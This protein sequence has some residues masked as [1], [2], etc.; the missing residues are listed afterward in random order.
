MTQYVIGAVML[1]TGV[2]ATAQAPVNVALAKRL[3]SLQA[4]VVS[5]AVG[6][7][8]LLFV[9]LATGRLAPGELRGVSWWQ[10]TGGLLGAVVVFSATVFVPRLGVLAATGAVI[11]GQFIGGA[12]IDRFGLIGMPTLQ[13]TWSRIVGLGLLS[14]GAFFVLRR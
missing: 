3:G 2:L 8:A 1:V 10:L 14:L 9:A 11:A 6:T 13:L 12:V 7:L 5:F 4:V